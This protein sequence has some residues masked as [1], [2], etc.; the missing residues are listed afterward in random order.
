[1]LFE[2]PQAHPAMLAL[3]REAASLTQTEVAKEMTDLGGQEVSQG[4]ISRAEAG[5]LSVSGERL[6]LYARAL[7]CTPELLCLDPQTAEVGI[8]LIHHRKRAALSGAALRCIHARLALT[9]I[10]IASLLET[11]GD[12]PQVQEF[13]RVEIDARTPP[14][15]AATQV[16]A[17]WQLAP[18]PIDDLVAAV[19]RAGAVVLV[20]DLGTDLLDAVSVWIAARHPLL[21]VN[22]RTPADR[23]RFSIAHEIGHLVM[24]QAPGA[25]ATQE[26]QA[27]EF[28]SALLMPAAEIRRDF[29]ARPVN[30]ARLLELKARWGVSMGALAK[31]AQQLGRLSDW[32][33]RNV[34]VEMSVLGYRTSEPGA[35]EPETP[36]RVR[37]TIEVLR[38]GKNMTDGEIAERMHLR[39]ADFA[40]QYAPEEPGGV[41]I[42]E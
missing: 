42:K 5:R 19:E 1:M 7:K 13:V 24:H 38:A 39:P 11:A 32:A 6:E 20:R 37:T 21:L 28:A 18:G 3:A 41:S 40:H 16:R 34:M 27:D 29:D 30:L 9:R 4:Y 36:A 10:Q 8:G 35:F 22:S 26:K 2:V 33:H 17:A 12:L 23:R 14:R 15:D 25:G 31:R